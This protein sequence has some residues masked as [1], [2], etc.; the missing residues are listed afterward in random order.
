MAM[1]PLREKS[2]QGQVTNSV[3][4]PGPTKGWYVNDNL[5]S[6][7]P[8]T[9][10]VL[11][12]FFPYEDYVKLRGGA[13]SYATGMGGSN[14]VERLMVYHGGSTE[15]MFACAGGSIY[16]VTSGGAVGA[17]AV[18]GMSNNKWDYVNFTTSGG[19]YL[20]A[21]NGADDGR[22][23]DGSSWAA[24]AITG[25]TESTLFAVAAFKNRLYF[26]KNN[27]TS[28]WYLGT[29]A[30][31]GAAT[32]FPV[33]GVFPLGGTVV[34][35]GTWSVDAG[36]GR[37]DRF[38]I[39]TSEGEVA[40]Y[41]GSYPGDTA[42]S[43][44]GLYRV[45]KPVGSPRCMQKFGGDLGILCIDG[46]VPLSKVLQLDSAALIDTSITKPI[47]PEWRRLM[48]GRSEL[49]GWQML[50]HGH[51]QWFI[52]NLPRP[53][54]QPYYQLAANLV[55]GAWCRFKGWDANCWALLDNDIYYGT[56]DG[57]VMKA[58]TG[59]QDDGA[60]Y[61]G[62]AF[63][64]FNDFKRATL[65]KSLRMGRVNM[66][67]SFNPTIKLS[68]RFDYNYDLPSGPTAST[69]P[70]SGAVW[71]TATWDGSSWPAVT[72]MNYAKWVGQNGLGT[73]VAPV[74]QVTT[75]TSSDIDVRLTSVDLTYEVGGAFG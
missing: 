22:L 37:D 28:I 53:T 21:V 52:V 47:A 14:T 19:S 73:M 71:D 41:S 56:S 5:A 67:S 64:S 20:L 70:T 65:R 66:Q 34:A 17:A 62:T 43:L 16:D 35:I 10:Y 74:V 40:I 58:D 45:G 48:D 29:D 6:M 11:E 12:N 27:S 60:P 38:V 15:K 68:P 4:I 26:V 75:G 63:F 61:T 57:R 42:W 51:Q 31:A 7:P 32:E 39:L 2:R 25:V 69:A 55:T 13:A 33:G 72:T 3:N 49:T 46:I 24:T 9:A 59:G 1:Q 50:V 23:Y 8:K 30:I 44:T 36:D 18:S 54:G